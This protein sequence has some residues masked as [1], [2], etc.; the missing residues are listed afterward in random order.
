MENSEFQNSE[1]MVARL[2]IFNEKKEVIAYRLQFQAGFQEYAKPI[3]DEHAAIKVISN[4]MVIGLRNLTGGKKAFVTFNRKL[5]LSKIPCMFPMDLLAVEI[6]GLHEPEERLITACHN[7]R[8]SRYLLAMGPFVLE[9][10]FVP[11]HS[12][13]DIIKI[14][15]PRMGDSFKPPASAPEIKY[16]A[17]GIETKEQFEAARDEGYSYFQGFFFREPDLVGAREMPGYKVNYLQILSKVCQPNMP[18]T[19]IENILKHDPS[20][21]HKLL[22]FINSASYGFKVTVRS[23]GHALALL[24]KRD[25]KKWLSIIALSGIGSDTPEEVMRTAVVRARLCE[26][27]GQ[28]LGLESKSESANFFFMGIFSMADVLLGRPML[29]VLAELP[30]ETGVKAALLGEHNRYSRILHLVLSYEEADWE[31][32]ARLSKELN[33]GQG[34]LPAHY[35]DA[36]QWAKTL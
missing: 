35:L 13:A 27:I 10:Q 14:D 11:F 15:Y 5:L 28:E 21:T 17:D 31:N 25:V 34:R 33:L 3:N 23:V 19:E 18:I 12:L 1:I 36:V 9:D 8:V 7:L 16:M 20:L 24:G 26:L 4:S 32:T 22:R 30:L 29:E 6:P 2:P